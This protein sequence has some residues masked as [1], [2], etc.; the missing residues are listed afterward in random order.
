M[1]P[2][3]G[4]IKK[5]ETLGVFNLSTNI[6]PSETFQCSDKQRINRRA[7]IFI[8]TIMKTKVCSKCKAEKPISE[9]Y[10]DT[11]CNHLC[12]RCK[13]CIIAIRMEYIR[14]NKTKII[15]YKHAYRRSKK[16]IEYTHSK[17]YVDYMAD[18]R[19]RLA[20]G[21]TLNDKIGMIKNQGWR[22]AICNRELPTNIM[23]CHTDHNHTTGKVRGILCSRCNH[24]LGYI[25]DS[26]DSAARMIEY[27]KQ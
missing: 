7:D 23:F 1:F 4:I 18:Y 5:S 25:R 13:K 3:C 12:A 9:F 16:Y 6:C 11:H 19:L 2:Y 15:E 14:N 10:F 27:L 26:Y 24:Y 8:R 21:I 17:K 20:Y 22:C